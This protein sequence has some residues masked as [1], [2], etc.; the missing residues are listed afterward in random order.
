MDVKSN[1][2]PIPLL[3]IGIKVLVLM[4]SLQNIIVSGAPPGVYGIKHFD[5]EDKDIKVL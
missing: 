1:G 2:G 4:T 5:K 3:L